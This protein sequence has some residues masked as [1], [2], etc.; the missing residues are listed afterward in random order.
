MGSQPGIRLIVI[1]KFVLV[2]VYCA[3]GNDP[4][5]VYRAIRPLPSHTHHHHYHQ[6][7]QDFVLTLDHMPLFS[8]AMMWWRIFPFPTVKSH[9]IWEPGYL[10][11]VNCQFVGNRALTPTPLSP[12][13]THNPELSGS[14]GTR[15]DPNITTLFNNYSFWFSSE[16][17]RELFMKSPESYLPSYGGFCTYGVCT[18]IVL[19]LVSLI[20]HD[21][22]PI[23]NEIRC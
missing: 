16:S 8:R 18:A 9:S 22:N 14:N 4:C 19:T 15:G 20:A 23:T 1:L 5:F 17:N 12:T 6:N 11:F 7:H 10:L 21:L 2:S 13:S 3:P